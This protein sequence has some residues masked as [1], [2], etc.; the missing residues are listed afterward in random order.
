MITLRQFFGFDTDPRVPEGW[1]S[2]QQ[3]TY[4]TCIVLITVLL[5][6]ILGKRY[7]KRTEAEK[8][9]PLRVAAVL[10]LASEI[11]KITIVCIRYNDPWQFRSMLPLFLC[12]IIFFS[13]PVA[14][15]GKGRISR[16]AMCF[17]FVYGMLCCLAGTYL[18][19][20][21]YQN[22]PIFSYE[23]MASN[24]AHC[25]AGFAA[26]YIGVSG[27]VKREPGDLAIMSLM[28]GI[29]EALA[30]T[31]DLLQAG[32]GYEHNYMFFTRPDG[33]PFTVLMNLAG[34]IQPLYTVL[35][36][37]VY[38]VYLYLFLFIMKKL[39]RRHS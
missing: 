25:V 22:S 19:A 28:L 39:S 32:T 35:V 11:A 7:R 12:S 9:V 16:S 10:M 1:L 38:F 21:I 30:L 24:F 6:V 29:F 17:T 14:A 18:A 3:L 4:V 27:L 23:P 13:L 33:T 8:R 34:G 20:N 36:A 31:A 5:A 2:W 15:F 26:V 37:A